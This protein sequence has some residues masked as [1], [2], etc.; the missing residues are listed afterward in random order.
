MKYKMI[1]ERED[2]AY[3]ITI[4]DIPEVNS[5]AY[6]EDEI[7]QSA[8][9]A[10]ELALDFYPETKRPIPMASK[11]AK[12]DRYLVLPTALAAKIY[13]YNE[14]L[15]S[16]ETKVELAAKIG[17]KPSNLNR[18]FDFRYRSKIEAIE[19]ALT[20]LGRHLEVKIA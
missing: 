18:L 15:A 19:Q 12:D 10:F 6:T 20:A 1:I 17:I 7:Q 9:E 11:L 4:P 2:D 13:L 14:W 5:V 8:L 16:N 3:V